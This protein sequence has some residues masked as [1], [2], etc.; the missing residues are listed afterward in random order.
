MSQLGPSLLDLEKLTDST[1]EEAS[2]F[3]TATFIGYL[4]GSVISGGLFGRMNANRIILIGLFML[5]ST[6]AAI[7][8][9]VIYEVMVLM[10]IF[11]GIGGGLLD[12]AGHSVFIL[13]FRE[14]E[15]ARS[16]MQTLHFIYA[17]G[18]ILSPIATSPFLLPTPSNEN[19]ETQW[20]STTKSYDA[21]FSNAGMSG[22]L[23]TNSN[24]L[25]FTNTTIND[26]TAYN[27]NKSEIGGQE[28]ILYQAYLIST[29]LCLTAAI[30]FLCLC[31]QS[32]SEYRMDTKNPDGMEYRHRKLPLPFK[33]LI[34]V[35][36]SLFIGVDNGLEDTYFGFFTAFTVNQFQ[37]T[38][39]TGSYLVSVYWAAYAFGRF[40]AIF[41]AKHFKPSTL[42]RVYINIVLA[43]TIGIF[44]STKFGF[45]TGIWI[46]SPVV[47][48]SISVFFPSI[49]LWTEEDFVPVTGKVASLLMFSASLGSMINPIMIGYLMD[50]LSPK[51][52]IYITLGQT[53][54]LLVLV[55]TITFVS[56]Q[57]KKYSFENE[58]QMSVESEENRKSR[59]VSIASVVSLPVLQP[60]ASEMLCSS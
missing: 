14:E 4:C 43:G 42:L 41:I 17:V 15:S 60:G 57:A 24:G 32:R 47:G 36:M 6:S 30:P 52:F 10:H 33:L 29:G 50:N 11:K 3:V 37:W 23:T 53:I 28:S 55:W 21:M 40:T 46:F 45:P 1:L 25:N 16:Y 48:F 7:P 27:D 49:L 22:I 35:L 20:Q 19:N 2:W 8:F 9:S 44:L 39:Q 38:K 13:K 5:A 59:R 51:W 34:L 56:R 12:A 26:S 58:I 18:G 54:V 31:W